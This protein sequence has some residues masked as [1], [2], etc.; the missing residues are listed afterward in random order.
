MPTDEDKQ[1]EEL[2]SIIG[3]AAGRTDKQLDSKM[4]S[5]RKLTDDEVKSLF[6]EPADVK[7]LKALM[8]IVKAADDDNTKINNIV[9]NSEEFAGVIL[10]L[11]RTFA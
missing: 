4:S 8:D 3:A 2:G 7:K 9:A 1:N 11:L 5:L 10:K 6:P